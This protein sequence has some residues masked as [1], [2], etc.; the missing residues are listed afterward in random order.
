[1]IK[2]KPNVYKIIDEY[3]NYLINEGLTSNARAQQKR[4]VIIQ[5]LLQNLGGIVSHRLSPYTRLGK[6]LG[7]RLYVYTDPKSK[8][9]FGFAYKVDSETGDV[10]VYMMKNMQLVGETKMNYPDRFKQICEYI[11]R[12]FDRK[13]SKTTF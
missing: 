9:Q 10:I 13:P 5:S 12:N 3:T 8:T 7:C 11:E 1:M 4:T 2:I 6:D